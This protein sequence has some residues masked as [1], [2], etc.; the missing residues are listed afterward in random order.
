MP[1]PGSCCSL[2]IAA[3]QR[4]GLSFQH[5]QEKQPSTSASHELWGL[6]LSSAFLKRKPHKKTFKVQQFASFMLWTL[7]EEQNHP[8]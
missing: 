4:E 7:E 2:D 1:V 5:T 6:W 3:G 8:E